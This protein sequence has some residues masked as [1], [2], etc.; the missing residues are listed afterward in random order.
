MTSSFAWSSWCSPYLF[1][2]NFYHTFNPHVYICCCQFLFLCSFPQIFQ[3]CLYMNMNKWHFW[4]PAPY[5]HQ[6][7]F[8]HSSS[9]SSWIHQ[10]NLSMKVILST[11]YI[12]G[13]GLWTLLYQIYQ[14]LLSKTTYFILIRSSY[15]DPL[16]ILVIQQWPFA[17]TSVLLSLRSQM[18]QLPES[19]WVT[20]QVLSKHAF[21]TVV[22]TKAVVSITCW[23]KCQHTNK[24]I[25]QLFVIVF[26]FYTKTFIWYC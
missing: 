17:E 3:I 2:P 26:K 25:H 21:K 22:I 16:H 20:T 8:E 4:S 23:K 18:N 12:L 9:N 19:F 15:A 11:I 13:L 5:S 10:C 7:L 14:F 6:S 1:W 24:W